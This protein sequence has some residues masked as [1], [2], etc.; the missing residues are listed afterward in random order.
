MLVRATS[1]DGSWSTQWLTIAVLDVNDQAPV[2]ATNLVFGVMENSVAGAPVGLVTA[3][4]ADTVGNLQNW[5]IVGGTGAAVFSIDSLTGQITVTSSGTLD[6]ESVNRWTLVVTVSDG[7]NSANAESVLIQV[8]NVNEAPTMLTNQLTIVQGDSVVLGPAEL[9]SLDPE[10]PAGSLRYTMTGIIAGQFEFVSSPGVAITSFTQA[11]IQTG[12]VL[13]RHDGSRLAPTYQVTVS[14]GSLSDGPQVPQITFVI[15][16][17]A[18]VGTSDTYAAYFFE[19]LEVTAPGVLANDTDVNG[20]VLTASVDQLPRLGILTFAANGSFTYRPLPG[21]LGQD[22]FQY[23]V[24]DGQATSGPVTVQIDIQAIPPAPDGTADE[25]DFETRADGVLTVDP[26]MNVDLDEPKY[27][28]VAVA[29]MWTRMGQTQDTRAV[30]PHRTIEVGV[31]E[32]RMPAFREI[33]RTGLVADYD[34]RPQPVVPLVERIELADTAVAPIEVSASPTDWL[35]AA[36]REACESLSHYEIAMPVWQIILNT[37][38]LG[39]SAG[40]LVWSIRAGHLV[41]TALASTPV[42]ARVDPLAVLD[43]ADANRQ[44]RRNRRQRHA[45]NLLDTLEQELTGTA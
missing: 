11:D 38:V 22:S 7:M 6:F 27:A 13:F 43:F 2:I 32:L 20:D 28:A 16:N 44:D 5:Q 9:H 18:P 29:P 14:D 30:Q 40:Y 3:T 1:A 39:A 8:T 33:D 36:Y 35:V 15:N 21:L 4:D 10:D 25:T 23:Q 19:A 42:W 26:A 24:S 34:E 12:Q 31:D 37:T 45:G 17:D 41:A